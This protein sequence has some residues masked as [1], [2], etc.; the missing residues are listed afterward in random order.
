MD[1]AH[2]IPRQQLIQQVL[3]ARSLAEIADATQALHRWLT[4]HPDD[5]GIVDGFE[6]LAMMQECAEAREATVA[7]EPAP[8]GQA[9]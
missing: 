6:A 7:P 9:A 8:A 5:L 3:G 2:N 1:Y 4:Q